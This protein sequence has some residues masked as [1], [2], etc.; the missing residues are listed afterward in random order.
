M[1]YTDPEYY[2]NRELSWLDFNQ[3]VLEEA[4]DKSNPLLE[5]VKFLAITASN[6]DEFFMVRVAGL[7]DQVEAGYTK[8]DF[9]GLMP[10]EQLEAISKKAHDMVGRQYNCLMRIILPNLRKENIFFHSFE[11]LD[12]EEKKYVEEYFMDIINPV[13]T[14]MAIDRSRPFPLVSNKSLNLGVRLAFEEEEFFAVVQVPSVLP[15]IIEIPHPSKRLFIF[16]EEVMKQFIGELF[17][18]HF[19]LAV[20]S[21]RITRNSD[22]SIDEE[23]AE[24]LL[25]EIE[26]SIRQRKWG[27]PVRVEMEKEIDEQLQNFLVTILE[28]DEE[29]IY[30]VSGPIDLT[31]WMN[32]SQK[33]GFEYLRNPILHPQTPKALMNVANMFKAIREGDILVHHPYESFDWVIEFVKQAAMDPKVLAIKQTLYRVSGNSPIVSALIQAAENGKQVTVLV[34]LKARFD[35]ENNILWARKLEKSGCHVIYGLV[36][37]KTHCKTLLVVRKEQDGIRRYVHVGTGNYNDSTA[38]VYTDLGLFTC[39]ET[40]GSDVSA[41]FNLL[42]G[43]SKPPQWK[44]LAVAPVTLRNTFVQWIEN[45]ILHV[46]EGREGRIIAKMNALVD[47]VIIQ[48]LYKASAKGVQIDLIVRGICCLKTGIHGVSENIRV[49]SIVDRFLEHSRVFCFGNGGEPKVFLSSADWMPRNLDR[50]VEILFPIEQEEI[51]NRIVDIL[52]LTMRDTVKA[53]IQQPDGSYARI[54]KR[55]KEILRSQLAFYEMAE[56]DAK[57]SD[58]QDEMGLFKPIYQ[59]DKQK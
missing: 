34:E 9:A 10:K 21:F 20:H 56:I 52:K 46:K 1:K 31:I 53:R 14:P 3:R 23:E 59:Q 47:P 35:E 17:H 32:F 26:R 58:E 48:A 19:I 55:G 27:M 15:R 2:I 30:K 7:T 36:G 13:L 11:E 54:D 49:M 44:K 50:R 57:E 4:L 41:L 8:K 24:D 51:K 45:E 29:D 33:K 16:I 25:M 38:K 12:E 40:F 37:L 43:F 39:R 5:R 22:L 6:L 42:T 18:G 28:L